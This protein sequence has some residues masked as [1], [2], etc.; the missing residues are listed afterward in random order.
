[1]MFFALPNLVGGTPSKIFYPRY[2]AYLAVRRLVKFPSVIATSPSP[3]VI[4]NFVM[5][6]KLIFECSRL[7]FF[8]GPH[9]SL[10]HALDSLGQPQVCVKI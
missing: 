1:M 2:R 5:N 4:D 7:K 9:P 3:K 8:G 10:G 6:F